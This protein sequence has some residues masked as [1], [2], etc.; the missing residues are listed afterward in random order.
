MLLSRDGLLDPP[1]EGKS[2]FFKEALHTKIVGVGIHPQGECPVCTSE[3]LG[4][5]KE[6]GSGTTATGGGS[7]RHAV[8]G[9]VRSPPSP[10]TVYLTVM[11]IPCNKNLRRGNCPFFFTHHK[12]TAMPEIGLQVTHGGIVLRPLCNPLVFQK[13][14]CFGKNFKYNRH[15]LWGCFPYR[16]VPFTFIGHHVHLPSFCYGHCSTVPFCCQALTPLVNF[17]FYD[18]FFYFCLLFE[19]SM[20]HYILV[21]YII[22]HCRRAVT[23]DFY[24]YTPI[25]IEGILASFAS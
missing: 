16:Q 14:T 1:A 5:P 12:K 21:Y 8:H 24:E 3:R 4:I 2:V 13:R 19:K 17:I 6:G 22:L 20:L 23:G 18:G 10:S 11:G 9:D 25:R 7:Y 15:I